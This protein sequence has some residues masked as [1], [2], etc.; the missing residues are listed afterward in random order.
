MNYPSTAT[1][2][3]EIPG[4]SP[5]PGK[6]RL[7]RRGAV[8]ILAAFALFLAGAGIQY[9]L[10]LWLGSATTF[11]R[12]AQLAISFG[13]EAV[14]F[15]L[16]GFGLSFLGRGYRPLEH[17]AASLLF[18]IATF[19]VLRALKPPSFSYDRLDRKSVV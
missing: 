7:R 19:F 2:G 10:A 3:A 15:L 16:A 12:D 11:S 4:E 14:W 6:A 9:A 13:A 1:S 5:T 8:L 17:L 18:G